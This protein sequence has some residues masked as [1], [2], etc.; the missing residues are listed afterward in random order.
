MLYLISR[1]CLQECGAFWGRALPWTGKSRAAH[2]P[3]LGRHSIKTRALGPQSA[4]DGPWLALTAGR[5]RWR[6][7]LTRPT[8]DTFMS[9]H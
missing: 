6:W 2:Q 1:G 7:A 9:R 8:G 3:M 4:G 5:G